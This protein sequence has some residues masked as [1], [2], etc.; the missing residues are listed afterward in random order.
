MHVGDGRR[1]AP[2]TVTTV[3]GMQVFHNTVNTYHRRPENT[4]PAV[5][6][7]RGAPYRVTFRPRVPPRALLK[8]P[9]GLLKSLCVKVRVGCR[10][11]GNL[12]PVAA[13]PRT[14]RARVGVAGRSL[15][16]HR[17]LNRSL[18]VI[19]IVQHCSLI[20]NRL[21]WSERG[22]AV[23]GIKYEVVV[24]HERAVK[25]PGTKAR[26]GAAY[27]KQCAGGAPCQAVPPFRFPQPPCRHRPKF[28]ITGM[29]QGA[30]V[31]AADCAIV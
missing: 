4:I 3:G 28:P 9:G 17:E 21:S 12:D 7:G 23:L 25:L 19:H 26:N 22:V 2:P 11:D 15:C 29:Q 16:Q 24:E 14:P 6:Q 20:M 27:C 18:H 8:G 10:V 31:V 5:R 13:W 1:L 30:S